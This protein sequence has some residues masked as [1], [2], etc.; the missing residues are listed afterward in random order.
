MPFHSMKHSVEKAT[1]K[2]KLKKEISEKMQLWKVKFNHLVL[3]SLQSF[4]S[5]LY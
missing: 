2:D 3:I 1:Q 4:N 5:F